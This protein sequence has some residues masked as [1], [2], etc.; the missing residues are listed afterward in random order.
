MPILI[1]LLAL[2]AQ[3]PSA[4]G[5]DAQVEDVLVIGRA[6]TPDPFEIFR[7]LCLDANRLD[8]RAFRPTMVPRW[9]EAS[10][11]SPHGPEREGEEVFVR[12]DGDLDMVLRITEGPDARIDRVNRHVCSVT[13]IGPHD[14]ESLERGMTRAL[15]D[16]GTQHHLDLKEAYPTFPGWTQ[17]AWAAIPHRDAGVWRAYN[18]SNNTSGG[19]V[20]VTDPSFYRRSTYLVTELRYTIHDGRPVSHIAMTWL[21]RSE[22]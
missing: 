21:S 1:S 16:R 14:Q 20:V 4:G 13:L 11:N 22:P 2:V 15:G 5:Q 18:P 3:D 17:R 10:D 9:T 7:A 8:G 19:F 6:A 12:R